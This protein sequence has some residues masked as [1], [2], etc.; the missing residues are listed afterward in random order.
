R[1]V[2][3]DPRLVLHLSDDTFPAATVVQVRLTFHLRD[4]QRHLRRL[5]GSSSAVAARMNST[6][7]VAVGDAL[8]TATS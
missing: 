7:C 4:I 2:D 5:R 3:R 8:L 6:C 1:T